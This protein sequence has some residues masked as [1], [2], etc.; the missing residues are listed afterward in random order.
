MNNEN[1]PSSPA[2]ILSLSNSCPSQKTSYIQSK[3]RHVAQFEL[4]VFTSVDIPAFED[5]IS[6]KEI[7]I[8]TSE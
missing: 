3:L 1:K 4:E 2:P 5:E 8:F 7:P 6:F